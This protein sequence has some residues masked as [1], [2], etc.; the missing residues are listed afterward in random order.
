[1]RIRLW[2]S[3]YTKSSEILTVR[4]HQI[5]AVGGLL[6]VDSTFAPPPIQDPFKWGADI[7]L[8]SGK[9]SYDITETDEY[10]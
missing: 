5:H 10:I 4:V 7:V 8:H 6:I 1:M 9:G 2:R 3:V